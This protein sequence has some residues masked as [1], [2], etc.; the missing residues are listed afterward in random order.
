MFP[1][2]KRDLKN[3][4][5]H[6]QNE[7]KNRN[8]NNV[9]GLFAI[10]IVIKVYFV[11]YKVHRVGRRW[12]LHH[13]WYNVPLLDTFYYDLICT[14]ERYSYSYILRVSLSPN[15]FP[16]LRF[17]DK[18]QIKDGKRK[19]CCSPS[20]IVTFLPI[21]KSFV[22]AGQ[23]C[24]V[25]REG[26]DQKCHK[27]KKIFRVRERHILP[28][29]TNVTRHIFFHRKRWQ[30]WRHSPKSETGTWEEI[31]L[32]PTLKPKNGFEL[33]PRNGYRQP[34][35]LALPPTSLVG[36]YLDRSSSW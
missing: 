22:P 5:Y 13:Y 35:Y 7:E 21:Q 27:L 20:R 11:T 4:I 29:V 8:L 23:K 14:R 25:F 10:S 28:N 15:G 12:L 1:F 26:C 18:W 16:V 30:M 24:D 6:N 9:Q 31:G 2:N 33:K 36:R 32:R 17:R 3:K 19:T 34:G